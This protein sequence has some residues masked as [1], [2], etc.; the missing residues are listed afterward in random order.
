M[1]TAI[2]TVLAAALSMGAGA[3]ETPK[4]TKAERIAGVKDWIVRYER[5]LAKC[6]PEAIARQRE[7]DAKRGTTSAGDME[8]GVVRA[9][10]H[11]PAL[12]AELAWLEGRLT[13]DSADKAVKTAEE[14]LA[15]AP[16][17]EKPDKQ[18]AL[19]TAKK[20]RDA[21]VKLEAAGEF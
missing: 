19:D 18:T 14:A 3:G 9:K 16:D 10:E 15:K 5:S 13:K 20:E 12:K 4:E 17:A 11:L 8:R 2:L 21:V 7:L 6:T 1:R